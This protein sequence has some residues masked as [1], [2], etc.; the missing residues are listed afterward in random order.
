MSNLVSLHDFQRRTGVSISSMVYFIKSK[1]I[2]RELIEIR[3]G[4][5]QTFYKVKYHECID[6]FK[7]NINHFQKHEGSKWKF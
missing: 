7:M 6:F 5:H 4:L 1:K 2:P 3:I